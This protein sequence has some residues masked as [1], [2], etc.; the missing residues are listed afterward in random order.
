MREMEIC[1]LE[2]INGGQAAI[3]VA[4]GGLAFALGGASFGAGW[5][6]LAIGLAF[7]SS[8]LTVVA[9]CGIAL[10]AGYQLASD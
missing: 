2:D 9:L 4:A 6:G 1:E 3:G 8:P 5:G 7:A 10:Y